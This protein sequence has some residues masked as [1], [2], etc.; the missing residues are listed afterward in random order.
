MTKRSPALGMYKGRSFD[1][2]TDVMGEMQY[3]V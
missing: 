3:P 1:E 2:Q